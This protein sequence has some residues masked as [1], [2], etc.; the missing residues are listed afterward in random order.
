MKETVRPARTPAMPW[1]KEGRWACAT[2]CFG[3]GLVG[4]GMSLLL[5]LLT[6]RL[7][8]NGDGDG[9]RNTFSARRRR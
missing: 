4:V 2:A 5:L 3:G 8:N 9:G 1:P 6:L 7:D